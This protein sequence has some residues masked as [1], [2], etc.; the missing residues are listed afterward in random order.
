MAMPP[1]FA[2]SNFHPS[3]FADSLSRKL[4]EE[5]WQVI[6]VYLIVAVGVEGSSLHTEHLEA[7]T[8]V[9]ARASA[10]GKRVQSNI[11]AKN[12]AI[13]MPDANMGATL[14]AL[15]ATGFGAAG[16]R[17]TFHFSS[18]PNHFEVM[19]DIE[20]LMKLAPASLAMAWASIVFPVP[21]GP[22]SNIPLHGFRRP[23]WNRFLPTASFPSASY[24][25]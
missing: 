13:V 4:E 9:H 15:V 12:H 16:Q 2:L 19:V 3:I 17:L 18:S 24:Y 5:I 7:G 20:T 22:N 25:P 21:G 10:N 23:H 11:G 8:Y 6:E 14:D 1:A